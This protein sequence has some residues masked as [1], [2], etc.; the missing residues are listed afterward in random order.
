MCAANYLS[1]AGVCEGN[2]SLVRSRTL[3]ILDRRDQGAQVPIDIQDALHVDVF[4]AGKH[5]SLVGLPGDGEV[6]VALSHAFIDVDVLAAIGVA[7]L[8]HTGV[9]DAGEGDGLEA[10][11]QHG[12]QRPVI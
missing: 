5:G 2:S 10:A 7:P 3:I 9:V 1:D 12:S 6:M 11:G 8:A 4:Q